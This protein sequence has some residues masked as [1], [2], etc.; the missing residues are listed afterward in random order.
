MKPTYPYVLGT[1]RLTDPAWQRLQAEA[2]RLGLPLTV[3]ARNVLID[4]LTTP[5]SDRKQEAQRATPA[6]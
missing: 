5:R 2:T 1:I 6:A 3:T 4:A